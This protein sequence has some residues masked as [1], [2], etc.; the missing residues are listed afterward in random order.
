MPE[1]LLMHLSVLSK[2]DFFEKNTILFIVIAVITTFV[3][4][5][6]INSILLKFSQNLGSRNTLDQKH[7]RWNPNTKPSLGGI[8]FFVIFLISFIILG[9]INNLFP[10]HFK[11][12]KIIGIFTVCTLAFIM[13]LAD[14]AYN[15]KPL[16]KFLTQIA[17]GLILYFTGTKINIFTIETLNLGLTVFW[18]AGIM[19]SINMLDNMDGITT[20]V[21]TI[22]LCFVIFLNQKLNLILS[23]LPILSL[24][25]LGALLGFLTF[26]WH[27]S[28]MFMGDTGSQFL[29]CF[30]A[31]LGI[32]Y[33]WN[34]FALVNNIWH[35]V[36]PALLGFITVALV[37]ILPLTDTITVTINRLRKGSSPF[38]G[39]KDHTTHHL[40]FKGITEKRIAILF[41]A[42]GLIGLSLAMNQI[43]NYQTNW[44]IISIIFCALTFVSLY[45][46]TILKRKK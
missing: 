42:I 32:D 26:N 34:S 2:M 43:L 36:D 18:V 38:V 10:L 6:V 8:S 7:I 13:G 11:N 40:F 44:L 20:I 9:F 15:T 28:K 1:L 30:L 46:N 39:G 31:I 33:C 27:P 12:L 23:P 29:G 14:D 45:L 3:F 41:F 17:C 24:G 21:S 25:M 5:A 19:N 22:I 37:F 4:S 35:S 16:L